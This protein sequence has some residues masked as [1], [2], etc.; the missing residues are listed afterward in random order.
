MM[1]NKSDFKVYDF[2]FEFYH[3]ISKR[4]PRQHINRP[5]KRDE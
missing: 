3:I 1:K 2:L 5:K 4:I